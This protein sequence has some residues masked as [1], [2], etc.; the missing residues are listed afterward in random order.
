MVF[1]FSESRHYPTKTSRIGRISL[2]THG[3]PGWD[4]WFLGNDG[5]IDHSPQSV[6]SAPPAKSGSRSVHKTATCFTPWVFMEFRDL[7]GDQSPDGNFSRL[8]CIHNTHPDGSCVHGDSPD[9]SVC[10]ETRPDPHMVHVP[11]GSTSL[12]RALIRAALQCSDELSMQFETG[13]SPTLPVL[14]ETAHILRKLR[15]TGINASVS[16]LSS[17]DKSKLCRLE[18][19]QP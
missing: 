3:A 16:G 10:W 2:H 7:F 4:G 5:M 6:A 13:V 15:N 12:P 11:S 18:W 8:G 9:Q 17:A 1:F 19:A 14:T